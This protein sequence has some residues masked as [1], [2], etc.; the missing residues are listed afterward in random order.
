M[1]PD[2]CCLRWSIPPLPPPILLATRPS[3]QWHY[4]NKWMASRIAAVYPALPPPVVTKLLSLDAGDLDTLLTH[5]LALHG[6]VRP[7][8]QSVLCSTAYV[9]CGKHV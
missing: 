3:L 1:W 8:P 2:G 7:V 4:Y 6:Q 9:R 5:P